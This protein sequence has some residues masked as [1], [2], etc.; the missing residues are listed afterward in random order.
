METEVSA[1]RTLYRR[2]GSEFSPSF[3]VGKACLTQT[4]H[5]LFCLC[6]QLYER[7]NGGS[8]EWPD[9]SLWRDKIRSAAHY[10]QQYISILHADR[11]SRL[12]DWPIDVMKLHTVTQLVIDQ[13]ITCWV[14]TLIF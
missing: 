10:Q 1:T 7:E 2:T 4:A 3:N 6:I 8:D 12:C 9:P 11:R 5:S 14:R 13:Y